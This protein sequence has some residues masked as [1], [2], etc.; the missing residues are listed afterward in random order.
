M[1]DIVDEFG[2]VLER[3]GRRIISLP[4]STP[5]DRASALCVSVSLI[6]EA[7]GDAQVNL[8]SSTFLCT[9]L[10]FFSSLF[11]EAGKGGRLGG[12]EREWRSPDRADDLTDSCNATCRTRKEL[13]SLNL[14]LRP[15]LPCSLTV[16]V[17]NN[18][19][20]HQTSSSAGTGPSPSS[21]LEQARWRPIQ[22]PAELESPAILNDSQ[23]AA[24]GSRFYLNRIAY[25][26]RARY[27]RMI[28]PMIIF[29]SI[30]CAFCRRV[31]TLHPIY[32]TCSFF[33]VL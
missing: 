5:T 29:V 25:Q 14:G 13:C 16:A 33:L 21:T 18:Q 1:V 10:F 11:L 22:H 27:A 8:P 3:E 17:K 28:P 26:C 31:M 12:A 19:H 9:C 24:R 4:F 20:R 30:F 2:K 23:A 15:F 7:T 6:D 32:Q